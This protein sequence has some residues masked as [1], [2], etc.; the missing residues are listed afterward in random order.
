M[1]IVTFIGLLAVV[2]VLYLEK[3]KSALRE[4]DF[5]SIMIFGAG[6]WYSDTSFFSS[7]FNKKIQT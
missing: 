6:A 4:L 3:Y 2:D 1:V 7:S 5:I